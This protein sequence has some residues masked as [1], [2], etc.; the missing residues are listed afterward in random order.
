VFELASDISWV[1]SLGER[2]RVGYQFRSLLYT[3]VVT[4]ESHDK[5]S[6]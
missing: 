1:V 2:R 6:P 4:F 5:S 3:V